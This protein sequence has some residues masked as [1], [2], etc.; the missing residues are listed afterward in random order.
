VLDDAPE[1]L[2]GDT[3]DAGGGCDRH[4]ARQHER[5]LLEQ[6]REPAA[7]TRPRHLD[8]QHAV[9]GAVG[10]RHLGGDVAVVLEEVEVPP[11][12]LGEVVGLAQLA[13]GRAREPGAALGGE[14]QV[15]LVRLCGGVE[16]LAD[17]RPRRRHAE[18]EGENVVGVHGLRPS[19]KSGQGATVL[20]PVKDAL[21]R[22]RGGQAA[23]L[24]RR[25]AKAAGGRQV[26]TTGWPTRSNK[27][28]EL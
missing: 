1:P 5:G 17:Q 9:L 22:C 23:I 15:Q 28:M 18:A 14:F 19:L 27:G 12:E 7:F 25:C 21:R 13:A 4:L 8:A 26:G 10:A 6:K 24:D 11:S 20:A 2:V 3:D 16:P